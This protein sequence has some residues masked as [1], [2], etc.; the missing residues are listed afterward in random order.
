MRPFLFFRQMLSVQGVRIGDWPA[1][2]R[3]AAEIKAGP[4][5]DHAVAQKRSDCLLQWKPEARLRLRRSPAS[6]GNSISEIYFG[7]GV[8]DEFCAR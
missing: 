7:W 2:K 1:G 4:L 8:T 6:L 3:Y 5:G